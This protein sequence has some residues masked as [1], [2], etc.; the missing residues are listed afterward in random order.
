MKNSFIFFSPYCFHMQ[1]LYLQFRLNKK[2]KYDSKNI[3]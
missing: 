1:I 3:K 2:D